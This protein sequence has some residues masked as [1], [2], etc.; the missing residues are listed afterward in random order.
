M[1]LSTILGE[2]RLRELMRQRNS[3]N[4]IL[5]EFPSQINNPRGTQSLR[6]DSQR[7]GALTAPD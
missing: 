6:A 4:T 3:V 7:C 2:K 5:E 1:R